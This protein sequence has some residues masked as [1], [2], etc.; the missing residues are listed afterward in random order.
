MV[1][2]E[3]PLRNLRRGFLAAGEKAIVLDRLPVLDHGAK[4]GH[5]G[6][7]LY[8]LVAGGNVPNPTELGHDT[9]GAGQTVPVEKWQ[10]VRPALHRFGNGH[11]CQLFVGKC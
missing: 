4:L 11:I 9:A 1:K 10:N 3:K 7:Q 8:M 6:G 2:N 5:K